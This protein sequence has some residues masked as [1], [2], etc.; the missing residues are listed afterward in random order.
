MALGNTTFIGGAPTWANACVG[1][2]GFPGYWDYAK[3]FSQAAVILIEAT[4]EGR[5]LNY[6][7]DE[8]VYPVCF[9]MRHSVELRLKGAISELILIEKYRGNLLEFDLDGSHDVGK[10]WNFFAERSQII[11]D[12]YEAIIVRLDRKISDFAEVDSTGQTFRYPINTDSQKHLVDVGI[13][14][15]VA[16]KKSFSVLETVL[17]ELHCLNTYLCDEYMRG[18][19]TKKLSR[20]NLFEIANLLP[21]RSTWTNESFGVTKNKIKKRFKIGSKELSESIKI[22]EV[23]FELAPQIEMSVPLLGVVDADI[24]EFFCHWFKLHDLP[25]DTDAVD[26]G[27]SEW[28]SS[29][30][31]QS[32]V[33]N[34]EIK[35]EVWG[36]VQPNLTP[37]KLAGLSALFYFS[38]DL[39]FSETYQ[40][41]FEIYLRKAEAAYSGPEDSVRSQ[42]FHIFDKTNAVNNMLRSIYFLRKL[43]SAERLVAAYRIDKK[44]S[45]LDKAQSRALFRKPDYYGY[46]KVNEDKD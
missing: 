24:N 9:N 36:A 18:T 11:D 27:A 33:K 39:D 20:K 1:E 42:Y 26:I 28:G 6:S 15:F 43:E 10:I 46:T 37:D 25:S 12:R 14:N 35:E 4:L 41:I 44:F 30:I 16:L 13:I 7:V 5:G 40:H 45:W 38:R 17:D 29:S 23:H 3:G 32:M 34:S 19:F 21:P 22:I 31:F 2:N 8:L